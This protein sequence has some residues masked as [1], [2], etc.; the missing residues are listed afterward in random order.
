MEN[1]EKDKGYIIID[2]RKGG[3]SREF[4]VHRLV[5]LHFIPN[6]EN[7]PEINH[8]KGIKS[9][10]RWNQLEWC[11]TYEN[12]EHARIMGLKK[13][14]FPKRTLILAIKRNDNTPVAIYDIEGNY[15]KSFASMSGCA[16]ELNRNVCSVS[17]AVNLK[18][19][20]A[21]YYIIKDDNFIQ[22]EIYIWKY[23]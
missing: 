10:N 21:G 12:N 18:Q 2:L 22:D 16:D 11:T 14:P 23:V 20:C 6:P 17:D 1:Q 19:K 7:K 3:K 9:D 4:K 13:H 8:I 15:I 5:G